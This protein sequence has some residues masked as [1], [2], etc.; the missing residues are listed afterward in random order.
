MGDWGS[1]TKRVLELVAAMKRGEYP[2]AGYFGRDFCA[3]TLHRDV[4]FL[5]RRHHAPVDYDPARHGYYLWDATWSL[6]LVELEGSS[7]FASLLCGR[8]TQSLLPEPLRGQAVEAMNSQLAAGNPGD[9]PA[10]LLTA[11]IYA[12]GAQAAPD[13]AAFPVICQAWRDCRRLEVQYRKADGKAGKRLVDVHALFLADGAWYARAW[14]HLRQGI[15]SLA[16]HRMTRPRLLDVT[17]TR[18]PAILEEIRGGHVFDYEM[19]VGAVVHCAADKAAVIGEREWFPG[20]EVK[21]LPE[22]GL[23]L[24]WPSVPREPFIH[25]ILSYAGGLT[26]TAPASL[27]A[28]LHRLGSRIANAHRANSPC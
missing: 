12:T 3:K 14:C 1:K 25:W 21:R 4:A 11:V 7:L 5:K 13:P 2:N 9:L 15:R 18:S 24:T 27:R 16:L 8:L 28:E 22:G 10:D 23:E 19:L 20:Q 6:P 26:A 17:F